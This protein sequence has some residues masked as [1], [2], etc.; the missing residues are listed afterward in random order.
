MEW[1]F[2]DYGTYNGTITTISSGDCNEITQNFQI[3]VTPSLG[4]TVGTTSGGTTSGGTNSSPIACS[5]NTTCKSVTQSLGSQTVSAGT[6]ITGVDDLQILGRGC[7]DANSNYIYD[8]YIDFN[9][10][11]KGLPPGNFVLTNNNTGNG[12]QI[13]SLTG[14]PT[15][16]GTYN[17]TVYGYSCGTPPTVYTT[18]SNPIDG[19]IPSSM[20]GVK[21]ITGTIIVN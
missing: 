2:S 5:P 19:D 7:Y 6:A 4:S 11:V 21:R 3:I 15:T 8:Q 13:V 1:P 17:Y 9:L 10:T 14:T 16:V 20:D 12:D 18:V